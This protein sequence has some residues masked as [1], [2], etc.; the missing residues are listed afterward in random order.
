MMLRSRNAGLLPLSCMMLFASVA[1][2][3]RSSVPMPQQP[4]QSGTANWSMDGADLYNTRR[5]QYIGPLLATLVEKRSYP[6][7]SVLGRPL[8]D[9]SGN[10]LLDYTF[11]IPSDAP[12]FESEA[13]PASPSMLLLDGLK[14][15]RRHSEFGE[16]QLGKVAGSDGASYLMMSNGLYGYLPVWPF[17]RD[18]TGEERVVHAIGPDGVVLWHAF[19]DITANGRM[20]TTPQG[21]LLVFYKYGELSMLS[22]SGGNLGTADTGM[23][24]DF[25]PAFLH[26]NVLVT[27]G[28]SQSGQI[29]A[30]DLELGKMWEYQLEGAVANS[31]V[32]AVDN[33][34]RFCSASG[35]LHCLAPDG[36][37]RWRIELGTGSFRDMALAVDGTCIVPLDN[38]LFAVSPE[39][40]LAWHRDIGDGQLASPA[41]DKDG[42][43]YTAGPDS[44]II[45]LTGEGNELWK[46]GPDDESG[47]WQLALIRPGELFLTQ[48]SRAILVKD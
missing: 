30:F 46:L 13:I 48:G 32:V 3:G 2:S 21:N 44:G 31:P 12:A 37:L 8:G 16:T 27:A 29:Q 14:E 22:P 10:I 17:S 42:N 45:C 35:Y 11:A 1:C 33:S 19:L 5:S 24:T 43:I 39:G 15:L 28:F 7:G 34:I 40:E 25:E 47:D 23:E 18:K 36:K 26:E 4:V 41:V 20:K 9:S 38:S 6:A